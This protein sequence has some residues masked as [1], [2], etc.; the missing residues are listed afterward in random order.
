MTETYTSSNIDDFFKST[1]IGSVSRAIGNNL[2][3]VNHMQ[4]P[5][6]VP[7]NKDSYGLT[8]F[9]RPQ[10][11]LQADNI[12]AYSKFYPML[13]DNAMSIQ[14][15]VRCMLDPRLQAGYSFGTGAGGKYSAVPPMKCPVVDQHNIFIPVLSNNL[16]SITGWPDI[17]APTYSS[18][19]GLLKESQS[20][21]DGSCEIYETLDLDCNF[22]NVRGDPIIYMHAVWIS[23]MCNGATGLF[24]PYPD[25]ISEREIDYNTRIYRLVLDQHKDTVTKIA[26]T[27]AGFPVA[28]SM[29]AFFDFNDEKPYNDQNN[30]F[31]IRYKV[32]GVL[33]NDDIIIKWFNDA[34]CIFNEAM[35]DSRRENE[36]FK[37][38]KSV[39]HLFNNRGYPRINP[40]TYELEWWVP[41]NMWDTRTTDF[42][43][44]N[45]AD[46]TE[47]DNEFEGG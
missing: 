5:G 32:D 40:K 2:Y 21:V 31:T 30:D 13:T 18:D 25:M 16:K 11:N 28:L 6:M 39:K 19:P 15:Y 42:L 9:T 17:T 7:S 23:Y 37:L 41:R 20:L 27:G 44:S 33:Y 36:L 10:L 24:T 8:F 12:R 43:Q 1:A 35:V 14:R 22:R 47:Q 26:C 46:T 34:V 4:V 29:G 38:G 3:G 45:L